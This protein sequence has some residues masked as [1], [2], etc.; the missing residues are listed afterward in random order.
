[1]IRIKLGSL[2]SAAKYY[3]GHCSTSHIVDELLDSVNSDSMVNGI[4]LPG[5]TAWLSAIDADNPAMYDRPDNNLRVAMNQKTGYGSVTWFVTEAC[6]KPGVVYDYIWI[7]NNPSPPRFD[8]R[9]VA[10]PCCPLFHDPSSTIPISQVVQV[11]E[12]FCRTGTGDRPEC[13][14]WI[15]G[16]LDG[17]RI[18]R[19]RIPGEDSNDDP[20]A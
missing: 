16:Q 7:S 11:V 9:V 13:I 2:E 8:P 17:E 18:D 3:G 19:S 5:R 10:D 4:W 15:R 14:D 1:M 20:W 6:Q 12:E